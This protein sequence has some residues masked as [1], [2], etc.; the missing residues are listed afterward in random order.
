MTSLLHQIEQSHYG[1]FGQ[2][3]HEQHFWA[4]VM[5]ALV[6][7]LGGVAIYQMLPE[8][9]VKEIP[10]RVLNIKFGGAQL[11]EDKQQAKTQ[12]DTDP[13][14]MR[15]VAQ[16]SKSSSSLAE[17]VEQMEA[18]APAAGNATPIGEEEEEEE[19]KAPVKARKAPKKEEPLKAK[20]LERATPKPRPVKQLSQ[21]KPALPES[22]RQQQQAAQQQ[23]YRQTQQAYSQTPGSVY[24]NSTADSATVRKRYTQ[25]LSL[26]IEKHKI[27]P[28]E[29]RAMGQGGQV[30]LRIRINRQGTIVRYYLEKATGYAAIDQA[31]NLIVEAANPVPPVPDH[32]P[33]KHQYLE[34]IIPINFKP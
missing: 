8:S 17:T 28:A 4:T 2:Y 21:K 27:Y 1:R 3:L 7:H 19:K 31:V 32:Y 11:P 16:D 14:L 6:L 20:K 26:W 23:Y 33:D 25:L 10:V 18:L 30:L 9:A 34:F 22:Y 12:I 13:A 29:A 24:G 5:L 15:E